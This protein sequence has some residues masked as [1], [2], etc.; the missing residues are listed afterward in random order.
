MKKIK[1]IN[2]DYQGFIENG[3]DESACDSRRLIN[4]RDYIE[5]YF[6]E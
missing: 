5:V 6:V 4:E 3:T 2:E 1:L